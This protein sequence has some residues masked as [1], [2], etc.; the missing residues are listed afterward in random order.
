LKIITVI[1]ARPQIIKAAAVSRALIRDYE[2]RNPEIREIIVHTGQHYDYN[3]SQA[4]FDCLEIQKPDYNLNVGSGHHGQM[5]AAMLAKIE[6]VL[7]KEKP[8]WV[9]VYGD[10]NSSLAG[11]LAA[12]KL[13]IPVAHVEAGLR[14]FNRHMPEE[15]NRVLTDHV[16]KLLFAPTGTAVNN[17]AKEGILS[18]VIKVG[19]VMLDNYLIFKPMA[20]Q[21]SRILE[22]LGVISKHYC[23]ATIHRQENTDDA[24]KLSGIFQALNEISRQFYPIILPLHPRTL[25]ALEKNGLSNDALSNLLLIEPVD[26]FDMICLQMNASVIL[27]DSGGIQKEAYFAGVPC[28]T[29]RDETEWIETVEAGVNYLCGADT[30]LILEAY[31]KACQTEVNMLDGLYGD[32][33][34]STS[35]IRALIEDAT[36]HYMPPQ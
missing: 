31:S 14:S 5:T 25:K 4:F 36:N 23:L 27:T 28:V 26:Y 3:M 6:D 15:I 30:T 17:L 24:A 16:S 9:L 34:A 32:G 8:D 1:G 33:S 22:Q 11:A 29:L 7:M 20:L 18:G 2:D 19:D 21:T 10:T 13:H 35:I 12:S